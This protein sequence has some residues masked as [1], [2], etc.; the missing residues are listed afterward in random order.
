ML[1]ANV[2]GGVV[3][4]YRNSTSNHNGRACGLTTNV[5]YLIEIL[6]QTTTCSKLLQLLSGCI[7]SKFYIKPQPKASL[8]RARYCCI[9]SKFYIKPQRNRRYFDKK[10][11]VSYR[12]STSNHNRIGA[13]YTRRS[14]VSYRNSTSNHNYVKDCQ[15]NSLLYLIEILHQTTTERT[16]LWCYKGLYLIEILH[17]TTT[18]AFVL[19]KKQRLYL[20]EILHQTT[21]NTENSIEESRLYLIEI[22]HQ[23]TTGPTPILF[24]LTLYLIEILHQTTTSLFLT[25]WLL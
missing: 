3:V 24:L 5:L 23:T 18:R 11:V 6:H 7:L 2:V 15:F 4:S 14:V 12:N 20:I 22:L 8:K 21:T 1:P 19:V 9:L 13:T 10:N 17:Q 25:R 16:V